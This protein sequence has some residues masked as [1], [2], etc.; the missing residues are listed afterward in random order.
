MNM[1]QIDMPEKCRYMEVFLL[2]RSICMVTGTS[3]I[4]AAA[5]DT[6][7]EPILRTA[8]AT[9]AP[10]CRTG[11]IILIR[12]PPL[13]LLTP[14]DYYLTTTFMKFFLPRLNTMPSPANRSFANAALISFTG[15]PSTDTP[16]CS[17]FL[18]ASEREAQSPDF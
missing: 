6:N 2:L 9:M 1:I 11:L 10:S 15:L 18:L 8:A 3:G 12:Y 16:P 5:S 17:T 7:T 14:Q 4:T 13:N